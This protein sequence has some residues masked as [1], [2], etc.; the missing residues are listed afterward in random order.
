MRKAWRESGP[1][2]MAETADEQEGLLREATAI[3]LEL[4]Q[5][6]LD[7]A[8]NGEGVQAAGDEAAVKLLAQLQ[9]YQDQEAEFLLADIANKV[10]CA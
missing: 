8:A 2:E 4:L 5:S 9:V 10:T 7:M 6:E 3:K 1:E